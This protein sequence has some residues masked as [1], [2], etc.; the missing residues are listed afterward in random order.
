MKLQL[1]LDAI[2]LEDAVRIVKQVSSELDIVELGTPFTWTHPIETIG[3]FKREFPHNLILADYK[4]MDGGEYC[5]GLAYDAGADITT[6]SARTL[7]ITIQGAVKAA[8]DRGR[9]ILAD[10]MAVPSEE[11]ASRAREVEALGVD[12]ICIHR[13]LGVKDS[14]LENLKILKETVTRSQIAI[15]GGI[16]LDTLREIV[17]LKPDL[18]I[19][20]SAI[21]RAENPLLMAR[22]M[23]NIMKEAE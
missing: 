13:G 5:A 19:V 15:A 12:Y 7:D 23:R 21:I 6:V 14:P 2:T 8:R 4:I 20:G 16:D 18:V 3:M 1:A 17:P 11:M 22:T 9:L 10:M